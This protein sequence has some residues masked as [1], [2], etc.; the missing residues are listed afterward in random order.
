MPRA[1]VRVAVARMLAAA[2]EHG[3][4]KAE[5][6]EQLGGS[7]KTSPQTVQ[8]V[9]VELRR[10]EDYEAAIECFGKQRRWR[11]L[12]PLR[13]PLEA[14]DREDL[15]AVLI[16]QAI[17]EPLA[18][19]ELRARLEALVEQLDDRVRTREPEAHRKELPQKISV[20]GA[21]TLG[22]RIDAALLRVLVTACRRKVLRIDYASPWKPVADARASYEIEPWAVRVH[23]GAVY[24]RAWRRDVSA[25]RTFRVTQIEEVVELAET[26]CGRVPVVSEI[27][28]D[29]HPAFG[30]DHDRP[31]TA[32]VR[33]R[34]AIA[35]WV[36]RVVWNAA[37]Q[38]RWI[39]AGELLE[40]T[41]PYRSCRELA[42]RLASVIDGVESIEPAQLRE[43][44]VGLVRAG[45]GVLHR[46]PVG[47]EDLTGIIHRVRPGA[48]AQR[49]SSS[50]A[51]PKAAE[52]QESW[53]PA[54]G[55]RSRRR[56]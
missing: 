14:P 44:V 7:T 1:Q 45:L 25:P 33:L 11:L 15:L 20:S 48:Q 26:P 9:L 19:D 37:Q 22:T 31:G 47:A 56:S 23:D 12:A 51:M 5:L 50:D 43:E 46:A 30:I 55:E 34:G 3:L 18:D 21:L 13:L 10:S 29:E 53:R 24:L 49:G 6:V 35:R 54:G 16:A 32:V 40:R 38:D 8:R 17:L 27:W 4:T 36:A 52:G 2:G 42:R 41:V 28:A 39:D